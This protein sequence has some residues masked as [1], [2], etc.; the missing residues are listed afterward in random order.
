MDQFAR[1]SEALCREGE[2]GEAEAR[3]VRCVGPG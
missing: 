1:E 3:E 2:G